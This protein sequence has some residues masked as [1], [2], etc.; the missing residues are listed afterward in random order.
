[1]VEARK[2]LAELKGDLIAEIRYHNMVRHEID[3]IKHESKLLMQE[4]KEAQSSEEYYA[5][6]RKINGFANRHSKP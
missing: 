6:L 5:V 1:M 2:A 4:L 3:G